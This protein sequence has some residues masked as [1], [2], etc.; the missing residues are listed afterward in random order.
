MML[1]TKLRRVAWS[2]FLNFCRSPVVSAASVITLTI[3]LFVVGALV[4]SGAFFNAALVQIQDKVDISVSFKQEVTEK[5]VLELKHSLELLPEVK[6]VI[7][8]SREAELADFRTRNADNLLHRQI[9][10]L[11]LFLGPTERGDI[12]SLR[13]AKI[14]FLVLFR[15]QSA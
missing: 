5:A 9:L 2:G 14:D 15:E 12:Y 10:Q 13:G 6:E 1:G 7:Y 3:T 8:S 11:L 4:L